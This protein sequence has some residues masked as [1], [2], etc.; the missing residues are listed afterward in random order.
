M[1]EL[2]VVN[3][4]YESKSQVRVMNM[5]ENVKVKGNA[6]ITKRGAIGVVT[7]FLAFTGASSLCNSYKLVTQE[8][9]P[10]Q[11]KMKILNNDFKKQENQV[12]I[13]NQ[14]NAK[15]THMDSR[16]ME[17]TIVNRGIEKPYL[18]S[19]NHPEVDVPVKKNNDIIF[20]K[21]DFQQFETNVEFLGS[22]SNQILQFDDED[23]ETEVELL[24]A[25]NFKAVS[26]NEVKFVGNISN[27]F[28]V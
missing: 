12:L 16:I 20:E 15:L 18:F 1:S 13:Y 26:S 9:E 19:L 14:S 22:I 7:A 23:I 11:H 27:R 25:P 3:A 8:A 17:Y 28:D 4:T 10:Q 5:E 2:L 6:N 21:I 24:N